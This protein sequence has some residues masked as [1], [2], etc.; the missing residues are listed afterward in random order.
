MKKKLP[1]KDMKKELERYKMNVLFLDNGE[2]KPI[3]IN[4][5]DDYNHYTMELHH[6]IPYQHYIR[7]SQWYEERGI[8]QKLIL[9]SKVCHEHIHNQGVNILTDEEF[10]KQY[11]IPRWELIFSRRHT[12]Y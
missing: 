5:L 12:E 2:L 10:E 9:V 8:Q 6:Y 3:Q 11:K 7:N 1:K 4:S